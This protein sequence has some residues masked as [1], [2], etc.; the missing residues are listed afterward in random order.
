MKIKYLNV[1]LAII[2]LLTTS[3]FGQVNRNISSADSSIT[4]SIGVDNLPWDAFNASLRFWKN[5][6]I[7]TILTVGRG[8]IAVST[9][10]DTAYI[11]NFRITVRLDRI[12]R[13]AFDGIQNSNFWKI[14]GKGIEFVSYYQNYSSRNR[15]SIVNPLNY[16]INFHLIIGVEH[17]PFKEIPGISYSVFADIYTGIKYS[18]EANG[19]YDNLYSINYGLK[20]TFYIWYHFK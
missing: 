18:R 13:K 20:P 2:L 7:N 15:S 9:I 17:F 14:N 1:Y 12:R 5:H 6:N 3:A 8:S 4:Y 10:N 16:A 11:D 19:Y